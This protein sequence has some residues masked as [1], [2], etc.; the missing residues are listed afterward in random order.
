MRAVFAVTIERAE[1]FDVVEFAVGIG[2]AQAV[3]AGGMH[4]FLSRDSVKRGAD[5]GQAVDASDGEREGTG[6]R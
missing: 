1:E 2:V 5:P 3:E 4:A 6:V